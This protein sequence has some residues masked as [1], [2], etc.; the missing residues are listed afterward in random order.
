VRS[1]LVHLRSATENDV[2]AFLTQAYPSPQAPPWILR[3]AGDPVLYIDLYRDMDA[4]YEADDICSLVDC[5]KRRPSISVIA[6]V[7][8]RHF[9][10]EE[11]REFVSVLLQVFDGIA[12]DEYT[13][14][15]WTREQVMSGHKVQDHTFFDYN[16]WHKEYSKG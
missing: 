14:H 12:Q 4:E 2:V 3:Q 10:D 8:G 7:S 15:C 1:I 11:V 6:D 5:L 13:N 16:G 9:G